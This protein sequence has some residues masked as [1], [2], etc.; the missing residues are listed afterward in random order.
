MSPHRCPNRDCEIWDLNK[1]IEWDEYFY[2]QNC[3]WCGTPLE[4]V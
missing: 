1:M 4:I 3:E 2:H